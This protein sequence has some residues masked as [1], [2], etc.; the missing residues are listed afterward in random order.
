MIRFLIKKAFFDTW[1]NL[2]QAALINLGA[3]LIIAGFLGLGKLALSLGEV[4]L[5]L[6]LAAGIIV[7][8]VYGGFMA[9]TAKDIAFYG[10]PS[11]KNFFSYIAKTWKASIFYAL[12]VILIFY[13]WIFLLPFYNSIGGAIGFVATIVL[14]WVIFGFVLISPWFFPVASQLDTKPIKILK[15]S[16]LLALDNPGFTLFLFF[17]SIITFIL[18]LFTAL[19]FPGFTGML[20]W[21]QDALKLRMYKYEYLEENKNANRKKI[22][23]DALIAEDRERVGKRTLRGM[24]FPWKD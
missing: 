16:F 19:L 15:K 22:P 9:L 13:T 5:P 21:Q 14:L 7:F 11:F 12:M 1:D 8:F 20:I 2:I 23:W 3:V 17:S 10:Q 18:S 24:I 4:M 6:T